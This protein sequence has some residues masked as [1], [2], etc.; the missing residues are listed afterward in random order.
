[1]ALVIG[2]LLAQP[3][4]KQSPQG[5]QE[6]CRD[7]GGDDAR[8][9]ALDD[10]ERQQNNADDCA[11]EK[12]DAGQ[13][14]VVHSGHHLLSLMAAEQE[15]VQAHGCHQE[16]G[17]RDR[18]SDG[19]EVD[20][21][22]ECP[23]LGEDGLERKREK[24]ASQQLDTG[25]HHAKLLQQVGPVPVKTLRRRLVPRLFVPRPSW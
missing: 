21:P 12:Q 2:P 9:V 19:D 18:A 25:L 3:Q 15:P 1:M 23:E 16:T 22:L 4:G 13:G 20:D 5:Q 8:S 10:A 24:E 14:K 11:G 17:S 6:R 7:T